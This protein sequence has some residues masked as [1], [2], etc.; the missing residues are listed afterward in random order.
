MPGASPTT[1]NTM[2]P[3]L[4]GIVQDSA[5]KPAERR[6]AASELAQ[7]FLPKK[8]TQKKSRRGNFAPDEYG[9][10]VDPNLARELRDT[11]LE[12]AC[13]PHSSKKRSPYATAQK[14]SKLQAR[15]QEIH[16]SLQCPCPS[17]YRLK[18]YFDGHDF[19]DEISGE[20]IR[21]G[22]IAGDKIDLRSYEGDVRIRGCL[23]QR[24]IWKKLSARRGMTAL[25][26][27]PKWLPGYDW[28]SFGR[29]N[30]PP[31]RCMGRCSLLRRKLL[32]VC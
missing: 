19:D 24:R 25:C 17:K 18:C 20:K 23:L 8:A 30:A 32:F 6:Q 5:T 15:I 12:L 22:E 4:L 16:E 26:R 31:I 13:L 14:A 7:Y 29:R 3:V 28:R 1:N 11:K 27:G 2:P 21:D 9:F 10:V